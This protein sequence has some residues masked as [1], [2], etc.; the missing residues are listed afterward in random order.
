MCVYMCVCVCACVCVLCVS[1]Y[2]VCMYV[3]CM[4]VSLLYYI[5]ALSN[6]RQS[7]DSVYIYVPA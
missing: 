6:E 1:V 2:L 7:L 4:C 3:L 5:N